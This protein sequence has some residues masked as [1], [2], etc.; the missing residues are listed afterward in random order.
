LLSD[1]TTNRACGWREHKLAYEKARFVPIGSRIGKPTLNELR[2]LKAMGSI[3]VYQN[4][5]TF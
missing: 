2:S 3:R 4:N 1:Q 5:A